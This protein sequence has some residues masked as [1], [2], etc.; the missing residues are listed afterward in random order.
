M[1]TGTI[2]ALVAETQRPSGRMSI[3]VSC[4]LHQAF[5][6]IFSF[7][8]IVLWLIRLF[9]DGLRP[10]GQRPGMFIPICA[11]AHTIDALMGILRGLPRGGYFASHSS[12]AEMLE[13]DGALRRR[14][15]R[16]GRGGMWL[17]KDED[18]D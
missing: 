13:A 17:G 16:F 3:I 6:W 1:L 2:G 7:A 8:L 15:G 9:E 12:A 10:P 18:K 5:G 4:L 14:C 11:L